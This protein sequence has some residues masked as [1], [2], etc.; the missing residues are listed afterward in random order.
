MAK[1]QPAEYTYSVLGV[2][3]AIGSAGV[4]GCSG[5]GEATGRKRETPSSRAKGMTTSS[6]AWSARA[7]SR[8][9]TMGRKS[10]SEAGFLAS[11]FARGRVRAEIGLWPRFPPQRLIGGEQLWRLVA[12]L[13]LFHD[14]PAAEFAHL[15]APRRI[16]EQLDDLQRH[17]DRVVRPRVERGGLRGIAALGEVELH[18]GLGE[19]HVLH[20]LVHGRDVVHLAGDV[21]VHAYVGGVEHRQQLGV[22]HAAGEGDVIGHL[23]LGRERFH[24]LER[25]ATADQAEVHVTAPEAVHDVRGRVQQVVDA[26]LAAHDADIADEVFAAPLQLRHARQNLQT[27]EARAAA[28]DEHALRRHAAALERDAAIG[29]VGGDGDVGRTERE[30]LEPQHQ[31]IEKVAAPEL[32]EIQLGIRVVVVEQELLAE[33]LVE[34]ADQ[35][36]EIGR[37]AVM[38][39]V[40]AARE[41]H[42]QRQH[43]RP[44]KRRAVLDQVTGGAGGLGRE[45]VAPD[46]DAVDR[47]E[48]RLVATAGGADDRDDVSRIAQRGG[49]LPHAPVKRRRE[50][51]DEYEDAL[52]ALLWVL[53]WVL[54]WVLLWVLR[55]QGQPPGW[56]SGNSTRHAG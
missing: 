52:W 16:I 13:E 47:P 55:R 11:A 24:F 12:P 15:A 27:L 6:S 32:R 29:L 31:P 8:P 36:E 5:G 30:L 37:I 54:V 4:T 2:K 33:D 28:H 39:D 43:E 51:L 40:E 45:V 38:D 20:D 46:V 42:P 9:L 35:E 41:E 22:R 25:G 49:F 14:A 23:E 34:P 7:F 18:H 3:C 1:F 19:R 44:E 17:V 26:F 10:G 56:S 50:I 48:M 21:G 53:V